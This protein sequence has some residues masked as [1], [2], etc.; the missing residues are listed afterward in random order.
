MLFKRKKVI[1]DESIEKSV[2]E[3][4]IAGKRANGRQRKTYIKDLTSLVAGNL[5][6]NELLHAAADKKWFKLMVDNVRN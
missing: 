5:T 1:R 2:I 6:S 4:K 3:G